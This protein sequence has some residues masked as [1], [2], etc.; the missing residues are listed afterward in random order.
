MKI[1]N[2]GEG[3]AEGPLVSFNDRCKQG[4]GAYAKAIIDEKVTS[5]TYGQ[6]I[7]VVILSEGTNYPTDGSDE[8][9][10][11]ISDIIIEDPGRNYEDGF[12]SDDIEPVIRNGR[13]EAVIIKEQI[14][15]TS[16]PDLFVE[17]DTGVGAVLRPILSTEREERRTDPTQAG[18]FKVIQCVGTFPISEVSPQTVQESVVRGGS[19]ATATT[20]TSEA[21]E[22]VE[23]S[24]QSETAEESTTTET[25]T[26]TT[27][28]TQ[29]QTSTPA[30]QQ[31]STP[32]PPAQQQQSTP[33]P[34]PP[35]TPPSGGGGYGY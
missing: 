25:T 13:V 26:Q 28:Q 5:P 33:P 18:A 2:P 7:K 22:D 3:Y 11:F 12:I 10:A 21:T 4:F 32:T 30:Q 1:T 19:T 31:Q 16:L 9:E 6:V 27:T 15:Y 23:T 34:T 20:T 14:P 17:S 29:T 8:Q 24:T 35:S